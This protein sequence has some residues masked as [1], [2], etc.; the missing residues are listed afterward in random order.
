VQPQRDRDGKATRSK[1]L[2][3]F[4]CKF[5]LL[6]V[7]LEQGVIIIYIAESGKSRKQSHQVSFR[8]SIAA[9]PIH[10]NNGRLKGFC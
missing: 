3:R 4:S 6:H 5:T 9:S 8:R 7:T 1:R 10:A 2:I